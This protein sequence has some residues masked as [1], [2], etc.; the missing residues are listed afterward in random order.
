MMKQV[1]Q[2]QQVQDLSRQKLV[3]DLVYI[4]RGEH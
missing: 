4:E 1:S 2:L 3:M